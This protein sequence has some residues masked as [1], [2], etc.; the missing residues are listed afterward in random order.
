MFGGWTRYSRFS[1]S[2]K[3]KEASCIRWLSSLTPVCSFV[4]SLCY[5]QEYGTMRRG[6]MESSLSVGER[7]SAQDHATSFADTKSFGMK[8]SF[9]ELSFGWEVRTSYLQLCWAT[10]GS[11]RAMVREESSLNKRAKRRYHEHDIS[12]S[13]AVI[14]SRNDR[15]SLCESSATV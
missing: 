2:S 3:T 1:T 4:C 5:P 14:P 9:R 12:N 11:S 6:L 15:R 7:A 8:I 13:N 10:S